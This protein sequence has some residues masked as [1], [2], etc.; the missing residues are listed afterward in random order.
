MTLTRFG[1][2]YSKFSTD[3]LRTFIQGRNIRS[4]GKNRERMIHDLSEADRNATFRFFDLPPELRNAVYQELLSPPKADDGRVHRYAALLA[5]CHQIHDEAHGVLNDVA[6]AEIAL[7]VC[8]RQPRTL[9]DSVVPRYGLDIYLNGT[10]P[11]RRAT[12]SEPHFER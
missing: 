6:H 3:E 1:P 7:R 12:R 4:S 5:A 9:L 2:R 11:F 10:I 8:R